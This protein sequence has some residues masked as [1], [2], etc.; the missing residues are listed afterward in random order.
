VKI[1]IEIAK[2]DKTWN[3]HKEIN[4]S[5]IK[6]IVKN[7][8]NRFVNFQAIKEVELSILLTHDAN[9]SYLNEKFRGEK[10]ATNVL[11]FPDIELH[12]EDLLEFKPD[13]NYMYLGDIAFSYNVILKEAL[14]ENK[15][16][17]QHFIHLLVHST[18]HLLGFDHTNSKEESAM[19]RLEVLI[20]QDFAIPSPYLTFNIK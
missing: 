20:L 11:S 13:L 16:F 8:L 17:E 6:T 3:N 4:K 19:R 12:Y 1:V 14:S 18:L 7:I 2:T 15:T 9:I 10:K 5:L